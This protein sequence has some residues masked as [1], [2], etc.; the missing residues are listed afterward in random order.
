MVYMVVWIYIYVRCIFFDVYM[1]D[2]YLSENVQ[3]RKTKKSSVDGFSPS[4]VYLA[5]L[6]VFV[7]NH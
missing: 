7:F 3:I 2:V 5:T 4:L 6:D 1:Y